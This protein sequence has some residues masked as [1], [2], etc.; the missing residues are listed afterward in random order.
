MI[1]FSSF[2][3][4]FIFYNIYNLFYRKDV[5]YVKVS[6]HMFVVHKHLY[7]MPFVLAS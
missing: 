1:Y 6:D 2:S 4:K 5:E 3:Q 7:K